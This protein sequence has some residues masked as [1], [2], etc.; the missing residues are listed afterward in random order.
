VDF[1]QKNMMM[2]VSDGS[3][4]RKVDLFPGNMRLLSLKKLEKPKVG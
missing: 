1:W 2:L 3:K 4:W